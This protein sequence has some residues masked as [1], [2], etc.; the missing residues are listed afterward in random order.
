MNSKEVWTWTNHSSLQVSDLVLRWGS[1]ESCEVR[2]VRVD[3]DGEL[4][5][6]IG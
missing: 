5:N 6:V 2:V 1:D 3:G 4:H